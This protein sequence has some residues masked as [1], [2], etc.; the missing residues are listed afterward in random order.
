MRLKTRVVKLESAIPIVRDP[1]HISN[2]IVD[3]GYLYPTGY[4]CEDGTEIN[5]QPDETVEEFKTR[6]HDS[7]V[8][9]PGNSM[10]IFYPIYAAI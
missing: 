8:W 5:Q 1:I 6:C 7:V 2:F 3:P 9:P 10:L 4:Y